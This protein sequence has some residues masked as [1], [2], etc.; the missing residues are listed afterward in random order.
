MSK[1][2]FPVNP[3]SGDQYT[4]DNGVT[5]VYDGIKWVAVSTGSGGGSGLPSQ[6]GKAGQFLR[7][8]GIIPDW[9]PVPTIQVERFKLNY[10]SSGLAV[11]A[12][13]LTTG[14]SQVQVE[15]NG[16]TVISF[17]TSMYNYPPG[18]IMIYGYDYINNK[19]VISHMS[20]DMALREIA[21]AGTAG[22]PSVFNG[23]S[24][25][26]IRLRLRENETGASRSFGTTTHAWIQ[27]VMGH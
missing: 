10:N 26:S 27:F 7:T 4:G 23:S 6:V 20:T 21:G 8:N 25:I 24:P 11:S 19:Y 2:I 18:S 5:Y 3:Q 14:I 1:L 15:G 13:D 17:N 22:N 16:D 12:T 9:E